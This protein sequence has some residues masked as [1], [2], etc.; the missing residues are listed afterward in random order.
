[1]RCILEK[2][3]CA[4]LI[5]KLATSITGELWAAFTAA[6]AAPTLVEIA[7]FSREALL[8]QACE[9]HGESGAWGSEFVES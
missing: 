7:N 5:V 4:T 3:L 9:V 1:M 8:S 6:G 2:L